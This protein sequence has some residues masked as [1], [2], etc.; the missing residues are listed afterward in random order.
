LEFIIFLKGVNVDKLCIYHGNCADG[1]TA[2][3]A[4]YKAMDNVEFYPEAYG[5]DP[6]SVINR[7][8]IMVDFSYK[9]SVMEKIIE[10]ASS[11]LVLDHH[12]SAERELH[13]LKNANVIIDDS[14]IGANSLPVL[15]RSDLKVNEISLFS[16]IYFGSDLV[17]TRDVS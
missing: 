12:A 1:F 8:I 10:D 17:P 7:D 5:D 15:K 6:P 16:T 9:R 14:P 3:W 2:A 11:V 13:G 4:V